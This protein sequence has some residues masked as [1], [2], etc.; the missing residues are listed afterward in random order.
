[1]P[2]LGY[3]YKIYEV[4]RVTLYHSE[5]GIYAVCRAPTGATFTYF[6][7]ITLGM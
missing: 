7:G 3:E 2:N 5:P 4:A 6:V 1:M